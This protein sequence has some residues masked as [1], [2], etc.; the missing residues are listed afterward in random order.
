MSEK[1]YKRTYPK[2]SRL[3][4]YHGTAQPHRLKEN[5]TVEN[6]P[7]R[8]MVSS[9]GT[10]TYKTAKY[11]ATLLWPLTPSQYNIKNSYKF[12]KSF[13][14]TKIPTGYKRS[15]LILKTYSHLI[16]KTYANSNGH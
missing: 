14:K 10:A 8:P 2:S 3:G 1:D 4:L 13:K 5:D 7:L 16:L 11:L 6:L 9:V 15:Y 12:V